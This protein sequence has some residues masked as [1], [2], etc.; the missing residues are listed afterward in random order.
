MNSSMRLYLLDEKT[1]NGNIIEC[2]REN[3][4]R[5]LSHREDFSFSNPSHR[6]RI[7]RIFSENFNQKAVSVNLHERKC[8][9]LMGYNLGWICNDLCASLRRGLRKDFERG[10]WKDFIAPRIPRKLNKFE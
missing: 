3:L 10:A 1:L 9:Q 8:P 6:R 4:F 7:F 2:G 5:V